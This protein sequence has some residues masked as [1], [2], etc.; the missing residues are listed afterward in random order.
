[1]FHP[2]WPKAIIPK[3]IHKEIPKTAN[4]W[5]KILLCFTNP[6]TV[7]AAEKKLA[8]ANGHSKIR[9]PKGIPSIIAMAT[10]KNAERS[11]HFS[12]TKLKP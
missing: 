10:A 3:K 4:T 5:P 1:M 11:A 7:I 8:S 2:P 9:I 6:K 12:P